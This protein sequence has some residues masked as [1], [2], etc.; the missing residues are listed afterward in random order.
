MPEPLEL[1]DVLDDAECHRRIVE[2]THDAIAVLDL[3]GRIIFVTARGRELLGF[4][5]PA[6]AIGRP[7]LDTWDHPWREMAASALASTRAGRRGTFEGCRRTAGGASTWWD[8][9]IT[10][11]ENQSGELSAVLT[12]SRDITTYKEAL[13][14]LHDAQAKMSELHAQLAHVNRLTTFGTLTASIAHELMQPLTA[15]MTNARAARRLVGRQGTDIDHVAAA[16]DDIIRDD[17]RVSDI[18]EHFRSRLKHGGPS[19]QLCDL[20]S[21]IE[22]VLAMVRAEAAERCIVL[23]GQFDETPSVWADRVQLQQLVLNLV[24]NAFDAVVAAAPPSRQVTVRTRRLAARGVVVSVE[25]EGHR[26]TSEQ[27]ARLW[28]PFYTT[29]AEGL[30]LGLA[31]CREI[32]DAHHSELRAEGRAAGGM[33]FSFTLRSS[34]RLAAARR[35]LPSVRAV[36]PAARTSLRST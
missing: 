3:D 26:V 29:K 30:G 22:D 13:D 9:A 6:T 31:I 24:M 7:W 19:K 17:Q 12:I 21:T 2:S 34:K 32:L 1:A 5:D 23:R 28:E 36:S 14:A 20:N 27:I 8:V 16:L 4:G 15:I 10:P 18:I 33:I 25:N 35:A 11:I